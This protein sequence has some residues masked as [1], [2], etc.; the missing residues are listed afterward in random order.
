MPKVWEQDGYKF[1][2]YTNDHNPSHVHV[3][4]IG[5]EVVINIGSR[6]TKPA[7]REIRGMSQKD[8][9]KALKI[10]AEKQ[11]FLLEEWRRIHD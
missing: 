1:Y 11:E 5:K 7:V 10:T 6:T 2:I 9:S 4:K 3:K 8:M